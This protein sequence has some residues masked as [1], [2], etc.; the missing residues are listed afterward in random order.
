RAA[1]T[2]DLA[3]EEAATAA[4]LCCPEG[5]GGAPAREALVEDMLES[6]PGLELLCIGGLRPEAPDTGSG[7]EFVREHWLKYEPGSGARTGGLGVLGVEFSCETDGAVA[8]LRGLFPTVTFH[9]QASE[10]VLRNPPP[11]NVG[12]SPLTVSAPEGT[13]A[14]LV[15]TLTS[16]SPVPQDL[17]VTY[18]VDTALTT[19]T[20]PISANPPSDPADYSTVLSG[21]VTILQNQ[22]SADI[23]V[24][25]N[26]D[27]LYEGDET[28][29]LTLDPA[30]VTPTGVAQVDNGRLSA[31]GTIRDDEAEPRLFLVPDT[32]PCEVV[33]GGSLGFGVRLRDASG[34]NPAPSASTVTVD[35]DTADTSPVSATAGTDYT[36]LTSNTVSFPPG[37]TGPVS[38]TV[39][40]LDDA[41]SPVGESDETFSVELQSQ[42]GAPLGS[43]SSVTCTILDDEATVTVANATADE[44]DPLT[45]EVTVDR[46]PTADIGLEYELMDPDP[47]VVPVAR[48]AQRGTPPCATGDDYLGL[49]T[50]PGTLTIP[51]GHD[52]S[53]AVD[54]VV[55]TCGD[56][57]AEPEER[58]WL[59]VTVASGEGVMEPD[60]GAMGIIADDDKP[61]ITVADVTADEG[62]PL[63]FK[64]SLT[65]G[66]SPVTLQEAVTLDYEVKEATPVS[67][68]DGDDYEAATTHPLT[69]TLDF[70]AGATTEQTLPVQLLADY[71]PN[72]GDETFVL[73]L[74]DG[75]PNDGMDLAAASAVGTVT[76]DPPPEFSVSDFT[77]PE[78]GTRSFTVTLANARAGETAEVDYV[79][80]GGTATA[81]APGV[82][83]HDYTAASGSLTGTLTFAPGTTTQPVDVS[84][85]RDTVNES[86]ETL[87]LTLANP[88]G[89]VLFDRDTNTPAVDAYGVGTITDTNSPELTVDDVSVPE[90][91]PMTFT[92]TLAN[93]IPGED[94]TVAYTVASRSARECRVPPGPPP[95]SGRGCVP[96]IGDYLP[97][98]SGTLTLN[99]TSPTATVQVQTLT[100]RVS[101][102][103]ETLHVVLSSQTPGHVNLADAVGVGTI[104][105]V[106]PAVV[107][108]SNPRATEGD[109]LK[110][111]ISL[112]DDMEQP[113]GIRQNVTVGYRTEHRSATGSDYIALSGGSHTFTP[114]GATT[115]TVEVQTRTDTYN[116]DDE[117]MALVLQVATN[118]DAAVLG[119]TE[120]TGTIV[121]ADPPSLF[122]G[123]AQVDEGGVLRFLVRLGFRDGGGNIVETP[124]SE[125]VL[126]TATTEDGTATVADMDY[127]SK[128][129]QLRFGPGSTS[130]DFEV[131]TTVDDD[132]EPVETMAVVLSSPT[133]ATIDAAVGRGSIRPVCVTVSESARPPRM[134]VTDVEILEGTGGHPRLQFSQSLCNT[135]PWAQRVG[136]ERR[137]FLGTADCADIE[138]CT[139]E[140]LGTPQTSELSRPRYGADIDE[141]TGPNY[142]LTGHAA[143]AI[144]DGI[145]EPDETFF[146]EY[147][148]SQ[149]MPTPFKDAP[150]VR[151]TVTIIDNDD[152]PRLSIGEAHAPE[153][154]PMSFP[155]SLSR[156]SGRAVSF[157]YRTVA[158]TATPVQDYVA[159]DWTLV[160][161]PAGDPLEWRTVVSVTVATVADSV[162]S[163]GNETFRVE[164]RKPDANIATNPPANA[165]IDD[166]IA[167]GTITEGAGLTMAVADARGDEGDDL[168]F[169]VSLSGPAPERVT[170]DYETVQRP[171]RAG[172]ATAGDDYTHSSGE[173][174]FAVGEQSMTIDVPIIDDDMDEADETFLLELS[175]PQGASLVDH[176]ALGS[177]R[178]S[179]ECFGTSSIAH[180][181]TLDDVAQPAV[182]S[183]PRVSED[184]GRMSFVVTFDQGYCDRTTWE[185]RLSAE[186][187]ATELL[188][189]RFDPLSRIGRLQPSL[190]FSVALIDDDIDEGDETI[191]VN[192]HTRRLRTRPVLWTLTGTIVDDDVATLQV[193]AAGETTT[194]EGGFLSFVM[195]LNQPTDED[196]TFSYETADGSE[197]A[198][199][200]GED[201]T[202][203]RGT[204]TIGPGR[205][206]VTVA[207]YAGRD[208]LFEHDENVE[209]R[210]SDLAGA[211]PDPD[212][213]VAVGRIVDGSSPPAARVSDPTADEGD[214]L[215]FEVTLDTAAGRELTVTATTRDGT[216]A[217][218]ADYVRKQ[219]S[220]VFAAGETS[221]T[222]TVET[223]ADAGLEGTERLFLDLGG[224]DVRFG[225]R[226]GTGTIRDVTQRRLRVSNVSVVE[227]GALRF[228]V[229]FDG[230]PT[231]RDITVRYET[232]DGTATA[233]DDYA[234]ASGVLTIGAG[235]TS[236]AV[237]VATVPDRLD[238]GV[239]RARAGVR[240]ALGA[241]GSP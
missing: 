6:R 132:L 65:L 149:S 117:T 69:G 122:I 55:T 176:S 89:A 156:R 136:F 81:P 135:G 172:A 196:V 154:D 194:T 224:T 43:T 25:L 22:S 219:E 18:T 73:E 20:A 164:I 143:T 231:G 24:A 113:A 214:P 104:T 115:H 238:E 33:E 112:V 36:A 213:M 171:Q 44:G 152:E 42:S 87:R 83:T 177:I 35:V 125:D 208:A 91:D 106:N 39:Q 226:I 58:F 126:V 9:G 109:P 30:S 66:G 101:E 145:D 130:V 110:F 182:L 57:V 234:A 141:I 123:D 140:K 233:G 61:T 161:I 93:P 31:T 59:D 185:V 62:D 155:V 107:R 105:N 210:I 175:D 142:N 237:E 166:A 239:E 40:T 116:E 128:S 108:V 47:N 79:I 70:A 165:S 80:G 71:V 146:M 78:G 119:D 27:D 3:A 173:L 157:E 127:T 229:G 222:V 84:L 114:G 45:F 191:I 51:A 41:A 21:T 19:A 174:A 5:T 144:A 240:G 216:A 169:V 98:P 48:H 56:S 235:A 225:D 85:R 195:R 129:E 218:G 180:P 193:P 204:R 124:T 37:D 99:D 150:W 49:A 1:L 74:S 60:G 199:T 2:A 94:V 187:T 201:Y 7:P 190:T 230:P 14:Q 139:P 92:V 188:D 118:N 217:A 121:D 111:E 38:V 197:P 163:E 179:I 205:L 160:T 72:E 153:G 184:A 133:N 64:V 75:D 186:S 32:S 54:L 137:M 15:F 192:V 23:T 147:R 26:D 63:E 96:P 236:A 88:S 178:G 183:S 170:V 29:V 215:E 158:G 50:P 16:G 203:A 189:F 227:G 97:V 76:D 12:F 241:G 162:S 198:A 206:S 11:P 167:V 148:W 212:G 28:L 86:D 103:P 131:Q 120:G 10:V 95:S 232:A 67:A 207:V 68:E 53:R 202:P 102:N 8:P 77:G 200:A 159:A 168:G 221:K 181:A 209:L 46:S 34:T 82:T 100:D 220:L 228:E 4:A 90:G 17:T 52:I 211:E 151:G 138:G 134:I 223:L 13:G